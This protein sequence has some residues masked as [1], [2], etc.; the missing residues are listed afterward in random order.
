MARV[1]RR[2]VVFIVIAVLALAGVALFLSNPR[3]RCAVRIAPGFTR[4]EGDSRIYYETGAEE[5]ASRLGDALPGAVA[6]VET[7]LS[8]PFRSEFRVYLCN[9]H[10]SFARHSGQHPR[11]PVR[12]LAFSRDIWLSPKAFSFHGQDTHE[13]TLAHELT[14]LHVG[15]QLGWLRRVRLVPGWFL[16]GLTD[17]VSGTG[18]EVVSRDRALGALLA[19]DR[20]VPDSTGRFPVPKLPTDYGI[21]GHMLHTQSL[22]FVEYLSVGREEVF[23]ALVRDVLT[24]ER[25]GP[26]FE[27]RY[28]R[29]LDEEWAGFLESLGGDV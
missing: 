6:T 13:Q 10:E 15:Q 25:F 11:T 24:G 29:T 2:K 21:D 17:W 4:L 1:S 9:S 20:F 3:A 18:L 28:G 26:V 22:M 5:I 19:G 14:H 8:M 16:E 27:E 7:A 12:G 23:H